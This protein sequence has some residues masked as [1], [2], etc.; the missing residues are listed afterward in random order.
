MRDVVSST[1]AATWHDPSM[2]DAFLGTLD[3]EVDVLRMLSSYR[4]M[5]LYQGQW[6]DTLSP[7]SYDKWSAARDEFATL[8]SAHT[9]KY[10]GD[11]DYPAYNLTAAE[12]GVQRA[13]RDLA[14]AWIARVLLLLAVA[15]VV[16]GMIAARTRLIRRPGAAAARASWLASTRPWRARESTLGMLPLDRWLMIGVPGGAAGRDA[17][18]ADVV[19][20]VDAS[21][22]SSSARGSSSCSWCGCSSGAGRRGRSSPRSAE[23]SCCAASSTLFALSFTGPGGYWFSFWTEPTARTRLHRDRVRAVRVGLRRRR[24]GAR[25]A[26]RTPPGD[27][28]GA[29]RRRAR[30][31]DP[32]RRSSRRSGSRRRSRS[33]TTRWACCRGA[34]RASS[35]SRCTSTSPPTPPLWA[36]VFGAVIAAIGFLLAIRWRRRAHR[37]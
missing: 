21:R 35:A 20:V 8:A 22:R 11:V 16:I 17:G 27:R 31:R 25:V 15:W 34:S 7:A 2:R 10:E 23:S 12:L 6:H 32:R 30:A 1:D 33:G 24:V 5:I 36:A 19:P 9:A 37:A 13:D 26:G 14:M 28:H 18:R 29:R 4:E 3:Y